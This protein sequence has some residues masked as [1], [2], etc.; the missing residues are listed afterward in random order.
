MNEVNT[1][2]KREIKLLLRDKIS[3]LVFRICG[4]VGVL[5]RYV[6]PWKGPS[7]H[8]RFILIVRNTCQQAID[9]NPYVFHCFCLVI[10]LL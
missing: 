8:P 3:V 5:I 6:F 4:G 2:Q 1:K 7:P 10:Y 9:P